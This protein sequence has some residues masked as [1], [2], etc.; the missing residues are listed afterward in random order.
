[1]TEKVPTMKLEP[2][3]VVYSSGQLLVVEKA[4]DFNV[5]KTHK[6]TEGWVEHDRVITINS[7]GIHKGDKFIRIKAKSTSNA[8]KVGE[9]GLCIGNDSYLDFI[10]YDKHGNEHP[11]SNDHT[12]FRGFAKPTPMRWSL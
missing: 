10:S 11:G 6:S 2:G 3:D 5:L 12:Q 8:L 9:I 4:V 7:T 1:M